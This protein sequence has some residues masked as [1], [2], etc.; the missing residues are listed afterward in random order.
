MHASAKIQNLHDLS[1][2]MLMIKTIFCAYG[3][4][5]KTA[6]VTWDWLRGCVCGCQAFQVVVHGRRDKDDF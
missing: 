4:H 1:S 6:K 3:M 2:C 5:A